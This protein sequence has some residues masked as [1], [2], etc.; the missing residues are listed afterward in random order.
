M[1]PDRYILPVHIFSQGFLI[2]ALIAAL[3]I[4]PAGC[5]D[6]I[7]APVLDYEVVNTYPHDRAAYT[8]GLVYERGVFYEGTG[9][10]GSSSLR[11]VKPDSGTVLEQVTLSN[12][13]FGEGVAIWQDRLIQLTWKEGIGFVYHK[14]SLQKISSFSYSSEGWGITSDNSRLIMSDG[15]SRLYFL[16]PKSFEQTGSLRVF[17]GDVPV[18]GL[19]ELEY[20]DGE[21]YANVWPTN[22]IA[23]ISPQSGRVRAWLDLAGI[24]P[25]QERLRGAEVLNGI[26][27]DEQGDRIFVTGKRWPKLYEIKLKGPG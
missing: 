6:G 11:K 1:L 25:V 7:S 12:D 21:I 13:Y 20:I 27:Y 19:N 3:W 9:L 16:D 2:A 26:A 4:V 22:L 18:P 23:I 15:T 17:D 5:I 24:L 14:D 10:Y 8:Q